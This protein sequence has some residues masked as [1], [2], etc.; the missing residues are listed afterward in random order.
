MFPTTPA[1][2]LRTIG[3]AGVGL[4]VGVGPD[5]DGDGVGVAVGAT[6]GEGVGVGPEG[7]GVGPDGVA[8]GPTNGVE[9]SSSQ[10]VSPVTA[11]KPGPLLAAKVRVW[12][13]IVGPVHSFKS[14][15][16][17]PSSISSEKPV[18]LGDMLPG[19]VNDVMGYVSKFTA[20]VKE[21]DSQK[22]TVPP[23]GVVAAR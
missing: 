14:A 16:L 9:M 7:V 21:S 5:G 1:V 12:P 4:G 18:V 19:K 3:D 15:P 23:P 10:Y 6:D 11:C 2:G 8:V 22:I 20:C 13:T 17:L